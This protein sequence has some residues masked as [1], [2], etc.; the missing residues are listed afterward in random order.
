MSSANSNEC[1]GDERQA[2][3]LG[4]RWIGGCSRER[5]SGNARTVLAVPYLEEVPGFDGDDDGARVRPAGLS[6]G[7]GFR[8]IAL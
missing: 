4:V 5:L 8:M 6:G 3:A 1:D 7:I 2:L